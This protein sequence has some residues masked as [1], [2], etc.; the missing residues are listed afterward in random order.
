[1]EH[2]LKANLWK[3]YLFNIFSSF[4]LYYG[5]D[6]VF[7][8]ARGLSVTDIV[9]VEIVYA[10][11][12]V[13]LEVPSGALADRWSRKYVLALNVV[14]FMFNTFLW[15]IAHTLN[16]FLLGAFAASIHSALRSG[17]DTSFLYDTLKQ[18]NK[19][20]TYEKT[21][22]NIVFYENIITILAGI[23]G[24]MAADRFGLV[25]PFW[26]TLGFSL[27]AV[28]LALSLTEPK[29]HRTTGEM[30]YWEHI[31]ETGKYLWRHPAVMHLIALSV[32][33]GGA[34]G[35]MDEYGQLYFVKI[36]IPIFALGCLAAA[37]NGVEALAGKFSY[38]LNRFSRRKIFAASIAVSAVGFFIVGASKSWIGIPFAFLP[39]IAYCFISPLLLSDLHKELP[40]GQR[41]TGESFMNLAKEAFSIP[42][43]LSFSFF[44]DHVSIFAAYTAIGVIVA[45]YFIAFIFTSYRTMCAPHPLSA[46]RQT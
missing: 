26:L 5:I 28:L 38:R 37:G 4:V 34:L 17:T 11:F 25:V 13:F 19:E 1:M 29:I 39:W 31:A 35:L 21:Y 43:A 23:I 40:S 45:I 30:K 18:L 15:A 27:I 33:L 36:G 20:T 24:A 41:A 10:V 2:R 3:F 46:R 7:M 42:V 44:A 12:V 32:I 8:A 16:V 6:K 9:L 14:F 22:G